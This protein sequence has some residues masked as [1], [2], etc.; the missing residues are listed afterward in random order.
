MISDIPG[1]ELKKTTFFHQVR[2]NLQTNVLENRLMLSKHLYIPFLRRYNATSAMETRKL[3][4]Y[5]VTDN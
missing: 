5:A 2:H 1:I 4:L 3:F